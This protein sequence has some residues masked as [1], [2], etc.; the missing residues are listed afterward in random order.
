MKSKLIFACT[1]L[2][3]VVSTSVFAENKAPASSERMDKRV[4]HAEQR[5]D[6][7]GERVDRRLDRKGEHIEH[8]ARHAK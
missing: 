6:K 7:K 2:T 8:R 3:L 5:L 4:D 1:F